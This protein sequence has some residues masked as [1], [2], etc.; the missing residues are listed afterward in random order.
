MLHNERYH[1]VAIWNR[2]RK[3]RDPKTGRRMQRL[4]PRS[5]CPVVES[6]HLRI[7]SDAIWQRVQSRLATVNAV[8]SSGRAAGLFL[9]IVY[10]EIPLLRVL[11]MRSLR[12]ERGADIGPRWGGM[13]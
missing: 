7:I 11:E 10:G 8:F 5:E 9:A 2:T 6:P 1:G 12:I 13:G 4:R 3:V